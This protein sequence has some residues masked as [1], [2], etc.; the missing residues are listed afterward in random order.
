MKAAI[1]DVL[2]AL[3]KRNI[4]QKIIAYYHN[5]PEVAPI[6]SFLKS[7]PIQMIPYDYTKEYNESDI[8]VK[9]DKVSGYRYVE[10]NNNAIYFPFKTDSY[11][12]ASVHVA[13]IEQDWRSPHRYLPTENISIQGD[14][15][16]LCGASDGIYTLDIVKYFRKVY[17]FEANSEWT[18]PLTYTLRNHLNK[19]EIIPL[20]ISD[21][22]SAESI[23]LD[24]FMKDKIG[25][26]NYIQADIEGAELRMLKGASQV[27]KKSKHLDISI[28]CYHSAEQEE[29]LTQFLKEKNF[30]TI[31]TR[32]F[33]LLWM[34]Y[35]LKA[36]YLR[37]GV[38]YAHKQQH[39]LT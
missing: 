6:I 36:P 22:N 27:L 1:R 2:V 28:C 4:T 19:V 18:G 3:Q 25:E 39:D 14:I 31:T 15:A 33:L 20:Y 23:T 21:H 5:N 37:R 29:E 10:Y 17:L 26:I 8:D 11:V 24:S 9:Y 30:S 16:V 38:I 7:N 12:R 32:G 34:Q 13:Q 35:P